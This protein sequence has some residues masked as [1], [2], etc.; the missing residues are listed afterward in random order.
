MPDAY[1][2]TDEQLNAINSDKNVVITA[3]PGSG[4]TTIMVNKIRNELPILKDY[5]GVIAITFTVKASQELEK[6]C[7]S[8]GFNL[9]SSFIG[10]IDHFV[11]SEIIYPF[12]NRVFG[13]TEHKLECKKYNDIEDRFKSSLP[14]L[15]DNETILT[16]SD[17][18]S[19]QFEFLSHY[20]NG[21]ILLEAVGV[22][23]NHIL[24]TS[25]ACQ[26]YIVAKYT[27]I[28][29]DEYQDSSEPQHKLFL[30]LLSLG[31]RATAVGD[32]KQSI[33]EWR[34]SSSKYI[35]ELVNL[36]DK[37]E[38]HVVDINHR[39]HPSIVN[40]ANRLYHNNSKLLYTEEMRVYRRC[41]EGT[42]IDL[43]NQLNSYIPQTA[44]N[45]N[46]ENLSNIAI[47]VRNNRSLNYLINNLTLPLRVYKDDD[48]TLINTGH[49]LLYKGLLKYYFDPKCL[50]NDIFEINRFKSSLTTSEFNNVRKLINELRNK[51]ELVLVDSL[52]N[53]VSGLTGTVGSEQELQALN[54]ILESDEDK[55]QYKPS[56]TEELQVMT[57]HK[58]KG[59]EFDIVFHLDLYEWVFPYRRYTGNWD[60]VV[61]P[62]WNQELNLH[63][64]G[65]TR[66]REACLLV[67]STRRLNSS[68][69]S[70]NGT[71]S[72]F[73][74]IEGLEGLYN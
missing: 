12:A 49:A 24:S 53:V 54:N 4:K 22:I 71:A 66:A 14:D 16:T 47:L 58:S 55:N 48:L 2:L 19:Y 40:Y 67:N 34:G 61:Y 74:N 70:R 8:G 41:F 65:I 20:Q 9:K 31:L 57:L 73:F 72:A 51:S 17:Y 36:T 38:H 21:F 44:K 62:T 50:V 39:C 52:K 11:L 59:L 26:R 37:F 46:I 28:Y 13:H 7:K 68:N 32:E 3:C 30:N 64:V 45:F 18:E 56:S 15:E 69:E 60:E 27:S 25:I 35:R 29:L 33:Y 10:T 63:Y 43:V 42:Q 5:Q 23:A 6:R 1:V